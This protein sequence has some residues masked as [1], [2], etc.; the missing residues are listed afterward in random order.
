MW[1]IRAGVCGVVHTIVSKPIALDLLLCVLVPASSTAT[2]TRTT[3]TVTTRILFSFA[4]FVS[5]LRFLIEVVSHK[6]ITGLKKAT[7]KDKNDAGS[8]IGDRSGGAVGGLAY[9]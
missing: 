3:T 5:P 4:P 2:I 9:Y 6:K 7:E 1:L 8:C